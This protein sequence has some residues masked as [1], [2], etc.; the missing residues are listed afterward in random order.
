MRSSN[1]SQGPHCCCLAPRY[2]HTFSMCFFE[3]GDLGQPVYFGC[4]GRMWGEFVMRKGA[5]ASLNRAQCHRVT[6][7]GRGYLCRPNVLPFQ[8]DQ[9]ACMPSMQAGCMPPMHWNALNAISAIHASRCWR[10][11][12]GCWSWRLVS[13]P[14]RAA[15]LPWW[16]ARPHSAL[17]A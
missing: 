14:R 7:H 15:C 11:T 17:A 12:A 1:L 16:Q 9:L 4:G 6:L 8:K 2:C 10:A 5:G 13:T 3:E